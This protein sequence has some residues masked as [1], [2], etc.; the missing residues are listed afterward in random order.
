MLSTNTLPKSML[1]IRNYEPTEEKTAAEL[2][3]EDTDFSGGNTPAPSGNTIP[4]KNFPAVALVDGVGTQYNN[5]WIECTYLITEEKWEERGWECDDCGA[6]YLEPNYQECPE[7][8]EECG[9]TEFSDYY[10]SGT[11]IPTT[12]LFRNNTYCDI[13]FFCNG[14]RRSRSSC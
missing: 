14:Y 3:I 8:C 4:Y 7:E 12:R 2:F 9:G 10:N 6:L 11:K 13:E 5:P 1:N